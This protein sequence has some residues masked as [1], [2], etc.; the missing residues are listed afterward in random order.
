M[1]LLGRAPIGL[2][3]FLVLAAVMPACAVEVEEDARPD[4]GSSE[5][6][7]AERGL[8]ECIACA[9]ALA[10]CGVTCASGV[11][12]PAC[13]GCFAGIGASD[14]LDCIGSI[15]GGSGTEPAGGPSIESGGVIAGRQGENQLDALAVGSDGALRVSWVVGAGTW[16]GPVPISAAGFAPQG[17][18]VATGRQGQDQ[19]DAFVVGNDGA[20]NA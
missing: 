2:A 1:C 8:L 4:T 12:A 20:L 16:D 17:A 6:V 9:G 18:H 15:S 7:L 3:G 5:T 11:G 13:I 14:C 19:L 10:V